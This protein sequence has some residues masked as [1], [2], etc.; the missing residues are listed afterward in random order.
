M[1]PE[2]GKP[3][4]KD[5]SEKSKELAPGVILSGDIAFFSWKS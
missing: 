5:V 4:S 1:V 2:S 3:E